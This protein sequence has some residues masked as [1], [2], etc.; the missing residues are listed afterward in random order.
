MYGSPPTNN[1]GPQYL[2][3]RNSSS[4]LLRYFITQPKLVGAGVTCSFLSVEANSG[5]ILEILDNSDQRASMSTSIGLFCEGDFY[6][7]EGD[8]MWELSRIFLNVALAISGVAVILGWS[9]SLLALPTR[10]MWKLLSITSALSAVVQVPIF[11]IFETEPCKDFPQ[12]QCELSTG[13]YLLMGSVI[14]SVFVTILTVCVDAPDWVADNWRIQ[15][16]QTADSSVRSG[17]QESILHSPPSPPSPSDSSSYFGQ[18]RHWTHRKRRPKTPLAANPNPGSMQGDVESVR[19]VTDFGLKASEANEQQSLPLFMV[20]P[21]RIAPES[22]TARSISTYANFEGRP[23]EKSQIGAFSQLTGD[24]SVLDNDATGDESVLDNYVANES[25]DHEELETAAAATAAVYSELETAAAATATVNTIYSELEAAAA[26]T[27]AVKTIYSELETGTA[28]TT[29]ANMLYSAAIS[30][31]GEISD[32]DLNTVATPELQHDQSLPTEALAKIPSDDKNPP[33]ANPIFGFATR[34]L[35]ERRR[36]KRAVKGYAFLDDDDSMDSSLPMSPPLEVTVSI[37]K[38]NE[39]N[40]FAA[41]HSAQH[42]GSQELLDDWNALHNYLPAPVGDEVSRGPDPLV[43]S[44]DDDDSDI[45]DPEDEEEDLKSSSITD[46]VDSNDPVIHMTDA[47][48]LPR[49]SP[50]KRRRRL[51]S[52][53]SISSGT[54]LL[55]LTIEEETAVDLKEF[56]SDAEGENDIQEPVKLVRQRSAPNLAAFNSKSMNR[57]KVCEEVHMEGLNSY[58]R[59]ETWRSTS[60]MRPS[61]E[62]PKPLGTASQRIGRS[63]SLTPLRG[64]R[65]LVS[66]SPSPTASLHTPKKKSLWKEERETRG[67]IHNEVSFSSDSGDE[68][69]SHASSPSL[70]SQARQARIKRLQRA[71]P[72]S[73]ALDATPTRRGR[74]LDPTINR[75]C[76]SPDDTGSMLLDTLDL[77]L[78]KVQRPDGAE[79]GPDEVSL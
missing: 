45:S 23:E 20:M 64:T 54:S 34:V 7:L 52:N 75:A 69:Q 24:E 60:P 22:T 47:G 36:R 9:I 3:H 33:K 40:D 30:S 55:D 26:A 62:S 27:A 25:N 67:G 37:V 78:A 50:T 74:T 11:L 76:V 71:S 66:R 79:Y 31:V 41:I 32:V 43:L 1:I 2:L 13:C 61:V 21:A 38:H 8:F 49:P 57:E 18:L 5:E 53:N 14:C 70:L 59:V 46:P 56:E 35:P 42:E 17:D 4:H 77:Q 16:G 39:D 28:A 72:T 48:H 29:T 6:D 51:R 12:Q 63:R 73:D 10:S 19:W 58:R 44:S 15:K 65:R 68:D